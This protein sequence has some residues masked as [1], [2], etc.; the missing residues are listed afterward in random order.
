MS[1]LLEDTDIELIEEDTA[2]QFLTEVDQ[3]GADQLESNQN[4]LSE[5]DIKTENNDL[6]NQ[7]QFDIP[8]DG[9]YKRCE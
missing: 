3:S 4:I 6:T 1:N 2:I 8:F 7:T 5:N 9:S